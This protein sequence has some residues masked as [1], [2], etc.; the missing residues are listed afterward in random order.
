MN[1]WKELTEDDE[2]LQDH[3]WYLFAVKGHGT[4][5]KGKYHCDVPHIELLMGFGEANDVYYF[6]EWKDKITHYMELPNMPGE[7]NC[8]TKGHWIAHNRDGIEY[9]ECE[10]C[11][12]WFLHE[13]LTRNSFCPNCGADM[14]EGDA[15]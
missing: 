6:W 8:R 7:D 14:R 2:Y 11:G 9:L 15:E 13:H 3:Y 4:P 10:R 1:E 12:I 5:L